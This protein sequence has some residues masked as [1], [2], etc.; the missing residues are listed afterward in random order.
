MASFPWITQKSNCIF[1]PQ[2]FIS[3]TT[4]RNESRTEPNR[5]DPIPKSSK[6]PYMAPK[7]FSPSSEPETCA[8][9]QYA[10]SSIHPKFSNT[11]L[12]VKTRITW[13]TCL[14][15]QAT[16][17]WGSRFSGFDPSPL[18]TSPHVGIIRSVRLWTSSAN[19]F[20][21]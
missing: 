9:I 20:Y 10:E 4:I 6:W 13:L 15:G 11:W 7:L 16:W 18:V 2:L 21:S 19:D 12:W 1:Q 14:E 3:F 17:C 8:Q 5:L